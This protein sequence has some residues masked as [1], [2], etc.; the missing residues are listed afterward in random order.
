MVLSTPAHAKLLWERIEA[1][2]EH[3]DRPSGQR[4]LGSVRLP[5]SATEDILDTVQLT[6][7][8]L[9]SVTEA[10]LYDRF[11]TRDSSWIKILTFVLSEY[12]Y[13]EE[14]EHGYWQGI[15][16]RLKIQNSQGV[17]K[18][19]QQVVWQG[20][21]E[22]GLVRS[23]KANRYVSTLWLQSGIPQQSL[24]HFAD[25]VQG[26]EY[27]WWDLA[28]ADAVDL[29]QLLC[30]TCKHQFPQRGKLQTFLQSSCPED[31]DEDTDPISG[32]L[33]QGLATV[34]QELERRGESPESL[35]DEN[36]RLSILQN[37]SLPNTFFLRNWGNLIQVLTP[38][39]KHFGRG[40][41]VTSYRKKPLSLCLDLADSFEIQLVLPEQQLCRQDWKGLQAGYCTIPEANWEGDIDLGAGT[42]PIP[43]L[44]QSISQLAE[45]WTWQLRS[46][47]DSVLLE[48]HYPGIPADWLG[49]IFDAN[50]GEL[51]SPEHLA[52]SAEII[53]FAP[54]EVVRE[55]DGNIEVLD[56]FVPCSISGWRG[57]LLQRQT[58][59]TNARIMLRRDKQTQ[60]LSWQPA[61]HRLP[62]LQGLRL[63]GQKLGF[64]GTPT[65]WYPSEQIAKTLNVLVEDLDRRQHL[66]HPD[67]QLH[68]AADSSWQPID[69][70]QWIQSPGCY[71]VRLWHSGSQWS[72]S[73][74][75]ESAFQLCQAPP[76]QDFNIL[77]RQKIAIRE[78]PEQCPTPEA[79]WLE[80]LTIK[81]LW[82]L[83]ELTF[84]LTNGCEKISVPKQADRS[85]SAWISLAPLRDAIPDAEQ[86]ALIWLHNEDRSHLISLNFSGEQWEIVPENTP[87]GASQTTTTDPTKECVSSIE[88]EPSVY[89]IQLDRRKIRRFQ[90]LI[91]NEIQKDG[92]A[93]SIAVSY[94]R[95]LPEYIQIRLE[96][97]HYKPV[98]DDIC[99]AIGKQLH[100]EI[101]PIRR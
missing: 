55:Y 12:A 60:E 45:E 74:V 11:G 19:L 84:E 57:H 20:V 46:H 44:R 25:L 6:L 63:K 70:N 14:G 3:R 58:S 94:D 72:T 29:A 65:L 35:R 31:S 27:D 54:Q 81:G 62:Q 41:A 90:Q 64:L 17:I 18:A 23:H 97:Q 48:W 21:E 5:K 75:I 86:Y 50:T 24:A 59:A 85:G 4:F 42:L 78:F 100:E 83:E 51:R 10:R 96:N 1:N 68:I 32:I 15:C 99:S 7:S 26:L 87:D 56:R 49:L 34:A 53:L 2:W 22:L 82:P 36:Q 98:L 95:S 92:M 101:M 77:N 30:D 61:N 52:L 71:A 66:T 38:R 67:E 33:L 47:T 8:R 79:F 37:Y 91:T 16:D 43:E 88:T 28:H 89:W 76:H 73:F 80:E 9:G 13:Y 39:Q 69:L 40:R 93:A